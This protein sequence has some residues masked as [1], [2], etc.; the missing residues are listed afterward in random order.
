[1]LQADDPAQAPAEIYRQTAHAEALL[2][3]GDT[4]T[5]RDEIAQLLEHIRR[6]QAA[7]VRQ[8]DMLIAWPMQRAA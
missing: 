1:M 6:A 4:R 3:R 2:K 5:A 8:L 7:H